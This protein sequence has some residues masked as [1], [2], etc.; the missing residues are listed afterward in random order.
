MDSSSETE[1]RVE[2]ADI[3]NVRLFTFTFLLKSLDRLGQLYLVFQFLDCLV[4]LPAASRA[5]SID[6]C[7][8][9]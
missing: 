9:T 5:E 1:I 3:R 7:W 4:L 8:I 2:S 6:V